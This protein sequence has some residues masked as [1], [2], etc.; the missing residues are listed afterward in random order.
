LAPD[1]PPTQQAI[2]RSIYRT[3]RTL[4][5]QLKHCHTSYKML[6]AQE[7]EIMATRLLKQARYTVNNIAH[8]LGYR[9]T[10]NFCRAF[11]LWTGQTPTQY[12]QTV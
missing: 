7:R 6:Q 1:L 2:F 3:E 12:R 11:K 9:E 5:R 4:I 8:V 10:A